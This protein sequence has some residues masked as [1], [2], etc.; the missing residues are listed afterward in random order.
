MELGI[1]M[2]CVG[3]S[4]ILCLLINTGP[5]ELRFSTVACVAGLGYLNM[6]FL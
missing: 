4:E 6:L 1:L 3:K 2:Q 5:Y